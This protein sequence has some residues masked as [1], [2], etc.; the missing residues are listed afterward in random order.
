MLRWSDPDTGI[1]FEVTE[2]ESGIL[3]HYTRLRV[4][5][6]GQTIVEQLDLDANFGWAEM[7]RW[8]DWLFVVN[9]GYVLGAYRYS[10]G[11]LYG[12]HDWKEL[13]F[14]VWPKS[15]VVVASKRICDHGRMPVNF[16]LIHAATS[17][18]TSIPQ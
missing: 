12:E 14:T 15:G 13:P 4:T 2:Q 5:A 6:N 16:P 17:Q 1:A 10:T 11:K 18:P 9:D 8:G 7:V 3:H